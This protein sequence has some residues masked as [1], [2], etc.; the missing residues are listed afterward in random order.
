MNKVAVIMST[1]NGEI[2]VQEQIESIL[3]Q[4][5][6]E[7]TLF[8]RDDGSKDRTVEIIKKYSNIHLILG[9]NIGVGNSFM[10]LLYS[11]PADFDYYAFSD[12][13][14]IWEDIKLYKAIELL[15]K[16]KKHLYISN[17]KCVDKDKHFIMMRYNTVPRLSPI[18]ILSQNKGTGCTMVFSKKFKELISE[19]S[20]RPS[21]Q[22]LQV[23]I[24]DVWI[25]MIGSLTGTIVYDSNAYILY[26]QHGN[27]VVGAFE[28]GPIEKLRVKIKKMQNP[29]LRNGR[30][31]LAFEITKHYKEYAKKYPILFTCAE[32]QRSIKE[33]ITLL[34]NYSMFKEY[35]SKLKFWGYIILG[36]F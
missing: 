20:R 3:S 27:N 6:V 13:D 35:N 10:E 29:Y 30:S 25:T 28:P 1:Y 21:R 12:Q 23:R 4:K 22:L 36:L 34:A 15:E 19:N 14:D 7:T 5:G 33:K 18:D 2:Y 17:Q 24:H 9:K 31:L 16:E 32:Y 8:I 26:R 11:V